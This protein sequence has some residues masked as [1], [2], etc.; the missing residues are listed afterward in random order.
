[1]KSASSPSAKRPAQKRKSSSMQSKT[2]W[3]KLK[4]NADTWP[5]PSTRRPTYATL[6]VA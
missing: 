4:T 6:S 1:M 3:A 2:D 5:R